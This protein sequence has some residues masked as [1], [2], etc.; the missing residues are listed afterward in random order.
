[1]MDANLVFSPYFVPTATCDP[2]LTY[3]LP[4]SITAATGMDAITHCIE[5]FLAPAYNPPAD[6]IAIE[7][8]RL[9][10]PS[11][12]DATYKSSTQSRRNMMAAQ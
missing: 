5:T 4:P 3:D 7:G 2:T 6:G 11:I 1:M 10:W 12:E 9:S 8:L